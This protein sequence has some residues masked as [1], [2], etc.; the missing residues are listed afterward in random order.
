METQ[1]ENVDYA[2]E[3]FGFKDCLA[4]PWKF[5]YPPFRSMEY[6]AYLKKKEREDG[7]TDEE[8]VLEAYLLYIRREA[9]PEGLVYNVILKA[10][11]GKARFCYLLGIFHWEGYSPY[12]QSSYQSYD[13]FVKA[14][15][16]KV[17]AACLY[18]G[19]LSLLGKGTSRN[20]PKAISYLK[21]AQPSREKDRWLGLA[22]LETGQD[23]QGI[24]LLKRAEEDGD[25][26][27]SYYLGMTYLQGNHVSKDEE[28][29]FGHFVL[30][31]EKRSQACCKE[32][33]LLAYD[34]RGTDK[35][36]LMALA[37]FLKAKDDPYCCF[38]AAEI[39][40]DHPS[41]DQSQVKGLYL[42]SYHLGYL[43]GGFRYAKAHL[44]HEEEARVIAQT[45][46]SKYP[47]LYFHLYL[48]YYH[49]NGTQGNEY[50]RAGML[51]GDPSCLAEGRKHHRFS[52]FLQ[53][54]DSKV[55]PQE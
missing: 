29:A 21:E 11:Q 28:A 20:V 8:E 31:A 46:A 5:R 10:N 33:A 49:Q 16:G 47:E 34:G 6:L 44:H 52:R 40:E 9:L 17:K 26:V 39:L 51:L 41:M 2:A 19:I 35:D 42:K 23:S 36:S 15:R 55:S 48:E 30:G 22:L 24:P 53:K 45:L 32:A 43:E 4:S 1:K 7:L 14:Y 18:L 12:L 25:G 54:L 27:S 37:Y 3:D 38:R 50:L 13:F